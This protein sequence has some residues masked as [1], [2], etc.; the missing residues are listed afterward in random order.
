MRTRIVP[1]LIFLLLGVTKVFASSQVIVHLEHD[2][3]IKDVAKD[4]GGRVL[5]E[6]PRL[7]LY[8]VEVPQKLPPTAQFLGVHRWE[9]NNVVT[10][11]LNAVAGLIV[12][13]SSG[14]SSV[15]SNWYYSQ[16]SFNM[17][18][19]PAAEL[20]S[21]GKGVVIADINSGFDFRHPALVGAYTS[22]YDFILGAPYAISTAILNQSD[23]AF[24]DQSDV[25][26]LDGYS[27]WMDAVTANYLSASLVTEVSATTIGP[28]VNV[29]AYSHGTL[30][31]GL[32]HAI[33]PDS[34]IMP[35]RAFDDSG[36]TDYFTLAKAI[37]FAIANKAQV[38]NMSW[39][40]DADSVTVSTEVNSA[41][42]AGITIVASAG[43]ANAS[44]PYYPAAYGGIISVA[45]SDTS[46]KKAS[47]SNYGSY[48]TVSAPGVNVISSFPGG[49]YAAV[50]GTSFSAPIV[51]AEAALMRA[52]QRNP[53][54]IGQYTVNI[55]A[56]NP[57]YTGT[58]GSGV[59]NLSKAVGGQ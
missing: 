23:V 20:L 12:S 31:A 26:F 41:L 3:Q 29:A 22:G 34:M 54:T 59:V 5:D 55:D 37:D 36:N 17:I 51:A 30:C 28:Q 16:P 2:K 19:R 21:T 52:V 47:F 33:A 46:N 4:M 24:L 35:L 49:Y 45:A 18:G 43:N 9:P 7:H 11:K 38:I 40:L 27:S 10:R 44:T 56:L 25:A 48:V 15:A 14:T 57:T 6:I 50:S 58:L 13:A 42:A 53:A 1:V 32:I 8:L 39:N